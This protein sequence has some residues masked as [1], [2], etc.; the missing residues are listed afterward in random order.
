MIIVKK[1]LDLQRLYD[2]VMMRIFQDIRRGITDKTKHYDLLD[3]VHKEGLKVY[4]KYLEE[5]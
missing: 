3:E 1:L 2:I 4:K 5:K